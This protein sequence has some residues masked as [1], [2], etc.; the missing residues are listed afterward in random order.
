MAAA[1]VNDDDD[2]ELTATI[3]IEFGEIIPYAKSTL[4]SIFGSS[5]A[6]R[7][8]DFSMRYSVHWNDDADDNNADKSSHCDNVDP[9][10]SSLAGQ[11][12]RNRVPMQF[13]L[14]HP[15]CRKLLRLLRPRRSTRFTGEVP[16]LVPVHIELLEVVSKL[17]ERM[18]ADALDRDCVRFFHY[19]APR[20]YATFRERGYVVT[21]ES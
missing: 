9:R 14:A 13:F 4:H 3:D 11:P 17:D 7:K 15:L 20:C 1:N 16:Q 6:V 19:W 10:L 18:F 12:R 2:D 5:G 8:L 21:C